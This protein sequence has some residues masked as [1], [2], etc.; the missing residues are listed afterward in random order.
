M[1]VLL[2][3]VLLMSFAHSGFAGTE[4]TVTS[5]STKKTI[6]LAISESRAFHHFN[7]NYPWLI[8][9]RIA[10]GYKKNLFFYKYFVFEDP[11]KYIG[12]ELVDT[13][14]RHYNLEYIGHY[15]VAYYVS[16]KKLIEQ[17]PEADFILHVQSTTCSGQDEHPLYHKGGFFYAVEANLIDTKEVKKIAAFQ[18]AQLTGTKKENAG[19]SHF[20]CTESGSMNEHDFFKYDYAGARHLL[21]NLAGKCLKKFKKEMLGKKELQ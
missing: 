1:K 21:H 13:V 17:F 8:Y 18:Q 11:A 7:V 14:A 15:S 12:H 6:V 20:S 2:L 16:Y 9:R 5:D 3:V 19:V 10:P 4:G